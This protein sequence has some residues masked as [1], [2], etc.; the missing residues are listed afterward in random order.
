MRKDLVVVA[1]FALVVSVCLADNVDDVPELGE[2]LAL[3]KPYTMTKPNYRYCTEDGDKTQLTDGVY[4]EGNFWTQETTV[5]WNGTRLRYIN[6]DLG[7]D[8]PIKGLSFN[9]AAGRAG[10]HWPAFILIFVSGDGQAWHEVGE[11]VALSSRHDQLP[12]YGEDCVRRLWT[13]QLKTHGRYVQLCIHPVATYVF[14]DEIEVYRGDEA[15][16]NQ[17]YEGEAVSDVQDH[18]TERQTLRTIQEQFLRD[19]E[20]VNADIQELPTEGRAEF[21][22]RAQALAEAIDKMPLVRMADF[23]AVLPMTELERD[24]FR[25]QAAVWR[26]Q[27]KALLRAWTKHRWEPLAPS[28]EPESS[29]PSPVVEVHMMDNEYRA[30]VFNLTN[31]ADRDERLRLRVTGLPGGENPGYIR[32]HEV[33]TVGTN[34]FVAVSAALPEARRIGRDYLITVPAGMTRQVWLSFHPEGLS[35]GIHAGTVELRSLQQPKIEVPIRLRIYPL[36]FPDETTLLVGGWSYTNSERVYGVTP[37]NRRDLIA[38]LQE[39]YVN[40]PWATS[41]ALPE[42]TYDAAGKMIKAPD[43]ANFD[44]WVALWPQAKMY[45][46]FKAVTIQRSAFAGSDVDTELFNVKVGNWA[47]FWAEHMREL[48]LKPSQLGVLICDEPGHKEGYDLI[49]AW[50]RAIEAAEP[51]LVTWEDPQPREDKDCLEMFASVD[52]LCPH[53]PVFIRSADWYRELFLGQLRQGRQLW[54]YSADGPARCFDPFSYYLVQEW[55]CFKIG[56]KGSCFWAFGDNS[57]V[58]CWNEYAAGPGGGGPFCPVY[59]DDTSV[60]AAKYM[61]AIREG[62]EDYEYLTMLSARVAELEQDGISDDKIAPAQEL[63]ATACD[64]VMAMENGPNYRWDEKKDRAI[65]DRVRIE[66]LRMLTDL[67]K[68]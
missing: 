14:V 18:M 58:S 67:S 68:L 47:H 66:I 65:A 52:V 25:L 61:E 15:W 4:T 29:G 31:A 53:R 56:A 42:G 60:T 63:L 6:I 26:A 41:A 23:R 20:A 38:H 11:L 49:T 33:L 55:H 45:M 39:H 7:R 57:R 21:D 22:R 40:A 64:R 2:N 35:P 54:F 30:G 17:P 37:R 46:V 5:G 50:A 62:V 24:V 13:D 27:N 19:L 36:R 32:V 51:D 8:Y 44:Q 43:T 10:V 1:L 12:D 34:R 28:E 9:T 59:L 48:G 3:G 16:A